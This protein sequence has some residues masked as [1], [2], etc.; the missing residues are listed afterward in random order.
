ML[1]IQGEAVGR[2]SALQEWSHHVEI[3]ARRGGSQG[4]LNGQ[5]APESIEHCVERTEIF[6]LEPWR[7]ELQPPKIIK[8]GM[9]RSE[10]DISRVTGG[11]TIMQKAVQIA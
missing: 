11:P 3:D 10:R 1:E 9:Y 2:E 7:Q 5:V 6:F 8:D 4:A